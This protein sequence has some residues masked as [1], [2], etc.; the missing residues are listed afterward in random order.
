MLASMEDVLV[1]DG[2]FY[3]LAKIVQFLLFVSI[4]SSPSLPFI[5][6]TLILECTVLI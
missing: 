4:S 5:I 1:S 3:F 2:E 6:D